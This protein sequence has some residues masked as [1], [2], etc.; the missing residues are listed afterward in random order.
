MA[1]NSWPNAAEFENWT[2][3]T[4][5]TAAAVVWM[6]HAKNE[7]EIIN[8][9]NKHLDLLCVNLCSTKILRLYICTFPSRYVLPWYFPGTGRKFSGPVAYVVGTG[10]V[11][12]LLWVVW[13]HTGLMEHCRIII[14]ETT[15]DAV[16][17]STLQS[18]LSIR[19]S[20]IRRRL[21][22]NNALR[23][24]RFSWFIVFCDLL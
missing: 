9:Y 8:N 18:S 4:P 23:D 16:S 11:G 17:V 13:H 19:Y 3:H 22:E 6:Y 10:W 2:T 5:F 7:F 14:K 1:I 15:I 12:H 21:G 20:L 24:F